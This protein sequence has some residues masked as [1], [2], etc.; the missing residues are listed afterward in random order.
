VEEFLKRSLRGKLTLDDALYLYK[1]FNA[2]DLLY[3][4]FKVKLNYNNSKQKEIK[5][6]SIINAKSGRCKENCIFCSQSIYNNCK[7][8]IYPLKSKTE[9][10]EYAK[11]LVEECCKLSSSITYETLI[12]S[13][14]SNFKKIKC[15]NM[16]SPLQIERFSIVS[17]GKSVNDDEFMEILEAIHLIK[18]ETNL[19]V[20]CS[21]GLLDEEKLYDLKKLDVRVHNNLE[22]SKDFFKNICSTHGYED[23]VDLIKKCKKLG[24]EVCSGGI[25]GLGESI[26]DRLSMAFDLKCLGV[27]SVPINLLHPIEG[28]KIYQKIK[29]R[30]IKQIT[31][32]EALKSIA[33][34][35]LILPNAEIRLAGGRMLNLGDFQSYALLAVDGLMVGN[36]LTTK[37]RS[38]KD[39]LKMIFDYIDLLKDFNR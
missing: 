2:I 12:G 28:T 11:K 21:L 7:I 8:P 27:D 37:G 14:S 35:K 3:L 19:K 10:L 16:R 23:K 25:F 6:C 38:L 4:A 9:I 33:L 15:F 13:E 36:Y 30:E 17:S 5:L 29:N 1:N 31:V 32:S 18:E 34:F 39:D 26:E 24:L 20:C 22:T